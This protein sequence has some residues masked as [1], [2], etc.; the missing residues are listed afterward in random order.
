MVDSPWDWLHPST[1]PEEMGYWHDL[2]Q[3]LIEAVYA[4][5]ISPPT[6][7]TLESLE[8]GLVSSL[9]GLGL[10]SQHRPWRSL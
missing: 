6:I 10:M 2:N 4:F 9:L 7:G 8:L 5:Y 3:D 1:G